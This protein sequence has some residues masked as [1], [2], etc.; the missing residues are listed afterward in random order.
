MISNLQTGFVF[1]D[2]YLNHDTGASH[3]ESK[4]RLSAIVEHLKK[5]G[6]WKE[7][8][9]IIPEKAEIDWILK[10]HTLQHVEFVRE[11]CQSNRR[12]LDF[13]DTLICRASFDIALL[14]AGGI[15]AGIDHVMES[16]V[17]NAFCAVRP[18]GHHAEKNQAMGFCLFNNVA[19]GAKYIQ[20]KHDLDRIAIID[21]D[22][23]HGNGTQNSFYDDPTVFY[24]SLHQFPHYP[25]TGNDSE[26]GH[27][28]GEGY[29]LNCPMEAGSGEEDYLN[30]FKEKIQPA[31]NG[32]KPDFILISAG[33]D[34]HANDPLSS[35]RIIEN[36]YIQMTGILK[37]IA[38]DHCQ[39][40]IV[41]ILEGG[42]NLDDLA[43]S[44]EAHIRELLA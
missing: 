30:A 7:L 3:P 23:H 27:G 42:Y 38:D 31:L 4:L 25:G 15:L 19:I 16:K 17:K 18:P 11:S 9:I 29:T 20:E 26:K 43:S 33:F 40:R 24:I 32:F 44:V 28:S 14:A 35:I 36:T 8:F 5:T 39:G 10:I 13:G 21:W 6:L 22:V 34:A 41:S 1:H 12:V 2:D 37:Q